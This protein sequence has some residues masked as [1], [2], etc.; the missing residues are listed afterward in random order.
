VGGNDILSD[1]FDGI[2]SGFQQ[3]GPNWFFS[4]HSMVKLRVDDVGKAR[5][6]GGEQ[7]SRGVLNRR[8]V[9]FR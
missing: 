7:Q 3:A 1:V 5:A 8:K 2:V 6:R 4:A 9:A